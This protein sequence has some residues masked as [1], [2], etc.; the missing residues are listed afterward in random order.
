MA[1]YDK[2]GNLKTVNE[3]TTTKYDAEAPER[4][5]ALCREGGSVPEFCRNEM[6]C[7]R[8]LDAWCENY[9]EMKQ[10]KELGK[11]IAEG[12]WIEQARNN[13][14][15]HSSKEY[16]TTKFDTNLYKFIAGGR[17]GHTGDK[18]IDD[19]LTALENEVRAPQTLTTVDAHAER[20]ECESETKD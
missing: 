6:I 18:N 20:A 3:K 17:F 13:L 5:L 14:V 11:V 10:A 19:R 4:Y 16:G 9:P 2:Y 12:W 8:T 15:T 7:R 1:T